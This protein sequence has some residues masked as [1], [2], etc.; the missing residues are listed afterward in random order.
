VKEEITYED[1]VGLYLLRLEIY[2]VF[3]ISD[4][5]DPANRENFISIVKSYIDR[6]FGKNDGWQLVFN[7]DYTKIRKD[8]I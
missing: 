4:K 5:V 1:R 2:D 8:R 3:V 7:S 6:N